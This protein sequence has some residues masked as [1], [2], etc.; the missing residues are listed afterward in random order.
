MDFN[1]KRTS[2]MRHCKNTSFTMHMA[3]LLISAVLLNACVSSKSQQVAP[4]NSSIY[5]DF[6][7]FVVQDKYKPLIE[8]H[9]HYLLAHK[10]SHVQI[11][12]NTDELGDAVFNVSLGQKL[13]ESVHA[14]FIQNGVPEAQIETISF[15]ESRP[16]LKASNESAWALNRRVDIVYK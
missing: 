4:S 11:Q 6:D 5:F 1:I 15:G 2:P 7:S 16:I 9:S 10:N 12:G 3:F 13:A 14:L 8:A